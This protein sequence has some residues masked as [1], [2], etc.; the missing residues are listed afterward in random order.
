MPSIFPQV[1]FLRQLSPLI[2]RLVLGAIVLARGYP[3]LFKDFAGTKKY[4]ESAGLRPGNLWAI[5]LGV[6]EFVG[7]VLLLIGLFTQ[8]ASI[9]IVVDM[10]IVLW[11]IKCKKGFVGGYEFELALLAIAVALVF[12]GA[13]AY[14]ID[15]PF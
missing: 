12:L 11:K 15:Y 3:K 9:L 10:L 2:L 5:I 6:I 4:F 13:G 8:L 1:L 14:A 7:G